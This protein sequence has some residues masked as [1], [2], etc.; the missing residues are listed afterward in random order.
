MPFVGIDH[1]RMTVSLR[2]PVLMEA[3]TFGKGYDGHFASRSCVTSQ[4]H[5]IARRGSPRHS[6]PPLR[7]R[8]QE[9]AST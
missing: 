2:S 7:N 6:R 8:W 3:R 1:C 9:C 5:T 4:S